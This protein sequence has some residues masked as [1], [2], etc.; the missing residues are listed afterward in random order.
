MAKRRLGRE[1]EHQK[2]NKTKRMKTRIKLAMLGALGMLASAAVFAQTPPGENSPPSG[3]DPR[4]PG[5][6]R[7]GPEMHRKMLLEKYDANKDG[8]L[9]DK[10]L[11]ALGKDVFE[12]NLPPPG[13]GPAG[14][15]FGPMA[16]G[17]PDRPGFGPPRPGGPPGENDG[18]FGPR[19]PRDDAGPMRKRDRRRDGSRF[20]GRGDLGR[21]PLGPGP[22]G[23]GRPDSEEGRKMME[24]HRRAFLKRYDK[25]GDGKLDSAER[26]AIG[27]DIE[28]GKLPPPPPP[29]PPAPQP[30]DQ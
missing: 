5:M 18:A 17:R 16:P 2:T 8:Q 25:N 22:H 7:L 24:E 3:P 30:E 11:S 9:D 21:P 28:E 15:G 20:D 26:E 1:A 14:P 6:G 4:R 23:L 10:E 29:P 12:G 13:R 27:K 19:G